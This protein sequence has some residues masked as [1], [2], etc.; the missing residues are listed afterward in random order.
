MNGWVATGIA[1]AA[2]VYTVVANFL[3]R[4]QRKA[5]FELVRSQADVANQDRLE[6]RRAYISVDALGK[7][8]G[9]NADSHDFEVRNA[10]KAVA[11]HIALRID[12][13]D[14]GSNVVEAV[15]VYPHVLR[16]GDVGHA[17]IQVP[18]AE[19]LSDLVV[20]VEWVDP[21]QERSWLERQVRKERE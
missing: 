15:K 6:Q 10:G 9:E 18:R 12:R 20:V 5:E 17:T 7:R 1:A 4:R 13:A 16:E 3:E 19:R 14:D 8:G 11:R 21:E 2:L